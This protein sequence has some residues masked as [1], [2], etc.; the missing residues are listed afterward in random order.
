LSGRQLVLALA[1]KVDRCSLQAERS[2]IAAPSLKAV[3]HV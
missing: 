1:A 3:I 2:H